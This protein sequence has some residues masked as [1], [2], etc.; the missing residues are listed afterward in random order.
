MIF[1]KH[2]KLSRKVKKLPIMQRL[3]RE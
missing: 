3:M 2:V 1:A